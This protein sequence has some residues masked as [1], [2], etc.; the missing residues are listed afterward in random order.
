M[1]GSVMMNGHIDN[2]ENEKEDKFMVQIDWMNIINFLK[3]W[4]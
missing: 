2:L 3:R 1:L 4:F